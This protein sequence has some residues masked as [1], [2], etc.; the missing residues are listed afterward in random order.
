MPQSS[1]SVAIEG[2]KEDLDSSLA[3]AKFSGEPEILAGD[4]TA[5]N[6]VQHTVR[7]GANVPS[8]DRNNLVRGGF[9]GIFGVLT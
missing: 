7:N 4:H 2:G 8:S 1:L 5:E 3:A 9:R 6:V